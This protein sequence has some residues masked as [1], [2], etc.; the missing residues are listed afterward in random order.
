MLTL[1]TQCLASV[2]FLKPSPLK[3]CPKWPPQLLQTISV[4]SIMPELSG[5][6]SMAPGTASKNA[7]QPHPESNLWVAR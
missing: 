6:S 1:L 2:G 5:C 7:G 3:I 4:R